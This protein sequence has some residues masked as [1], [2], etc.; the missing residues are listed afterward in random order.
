MAVGIMR[1]ELVNKARKFD[2]KLLIFVA[3]PRGKKYFTMNYVF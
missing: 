3:Y 2:L 1:V